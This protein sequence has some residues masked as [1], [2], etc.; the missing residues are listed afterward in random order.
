MAKKRID[1]QR[2]IKVNDVRITKAIQDIEAATAGDRVTIYFND[3]IGGS[4]Q[5][6]L[7]LIEAIERSD[8]A[9]RI[10]LIFKTYAISAAAFIMCYFAF[11]NVVTTNVR[12]QLD[13][14]VCVVYHKPRAETAL[15]TYFAS[16]LFDHLQ[17][18]P[19]LEFIKYITPTFDDVFDSLL[20]GCQSKGIRIAPHMKSVYN[21][22]GDVS[23]VFNGGTL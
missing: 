22:N 14:N 3:N 21:I 13:G 23:V 16:G 19:V 20:T 6:A 8:P 5:D 18:Q 12:V 15:H 17:Y 4:I 2:E 1:I 7:T 9:I 11:Y 10:F